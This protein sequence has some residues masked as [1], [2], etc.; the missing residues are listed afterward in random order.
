LFKFDKKGDLVFN[1]GL[2][3]AA[4]GWPGAPESDYHGEGPPPLPVS[5]DAGNFDGAG[6]LKS[7]GT[8]WN[9]GDKYRVTFTKAGTYPYACL[10][11]PG[12]IGKVVVK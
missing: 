1:E 2:D 4:G 7:S 9:N 5:V 11:H 12:M 6:G 3:K 8:G 10:I